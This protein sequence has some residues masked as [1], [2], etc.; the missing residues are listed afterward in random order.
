MKEQSSIRIVN[1][2]EVRRR[3]DRGEYEV[4]GRES[5]TVTKDVPADSIESLTNFLSEG[6]QVNAAFAATCSNSAIW[7]A[8]QVVNREAQKQIAAKQHREQIATRAS[9]YFA[10]EKE[11]RAY[12]DGEADDIPSAPR[13][14]MNGEPDPDQAPVAN[15]AATVPSEDP[16]DE[17]EPLG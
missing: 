1:T 16:G 5:H 12:L 10:N 14:V 11:V 7:E 13:F 6:Q 8:L 4:I 2:T 9:R 15:P 17:A 3:N